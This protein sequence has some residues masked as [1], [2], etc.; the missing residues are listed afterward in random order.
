MPSLIIAELPVKLA[1]ANF[2]TA[3]S[4]LPTRAAYIAVLDDP[5]I[6][7]FASKCDDHAETDNPN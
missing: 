6:L 3:I 1:A 7:K 2:V 4:E 5:A